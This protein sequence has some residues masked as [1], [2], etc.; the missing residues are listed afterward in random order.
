MALDRDE[1]T[2]SDGN[3]NCGM[4]AN[5]DQLNF[6]GDAEGDLCDSDDDND[7]LSDEEELLLGTMVLNPDTDGDGF[8]DGTEVL[9]GSDPLS[10]SSTPDSVNVP[11]LP[12]L[13]L[14][15]LGLMVVFGRQGLYLRPGA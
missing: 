3:D 11:F 10:A 15:L 8:D 2:V 12:T 13:G 7:S 5:L 9:A 6:D 4:L 1:D 14:L